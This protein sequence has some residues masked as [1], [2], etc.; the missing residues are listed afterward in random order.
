M[1]VDFNSA[2]GSFRTGQLADGY[3][4]FIKL[5]N[6]GHADGA[7]YALLMCEHGL[8]LF[9]RDWDCAPDSVTAWARLARVPAPRIGMR[10]YA[11]SDSPRM[12]EHR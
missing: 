8:E 7:R 3:G 4:S 5:A 11:E 10:H 9:G 6:Q 12:S 2:I 1:S